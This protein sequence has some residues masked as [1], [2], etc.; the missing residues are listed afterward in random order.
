MA[1]PLG[2]EHV[3]YNYY[4]DSQPEGERN[5]EQPLSQSPVGAARRRKKTV[6]Q[7]DAISG[8]ISSLTSHKDIVC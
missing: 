3:S 2:N 4:T 6:K 7:Y 1:P 5:L 8:T